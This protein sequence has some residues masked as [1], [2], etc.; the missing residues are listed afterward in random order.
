MVNSGLIHPYS[1][2]FVRISIRAVAPPTPIIIPT[3]AYMGS[4]RVSHLPVCANLSVRFP[5]TVS[6]RRRG[7]GHAHPVLGMTTLCIWDSDLFY[8]LWFI[9]CVGRTLISGLGFLLFLASGAF[10]FC[11]RPAHNSRVERYSGYPIAASFTGMWVALNGDWTFLDTLLT[12][13]RWVVW[14]G[15]G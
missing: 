10:P 6:F 7:V 3:S 9:L 4:L 13:I 1:C 8:T 12:R 11:L 14:Y 5:T 15:T 2:F